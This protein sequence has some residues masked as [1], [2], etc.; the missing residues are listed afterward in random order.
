MSH[1][2]ERQVISAQADDVSRELTV[3]RD[4]G[5]QHT[6]QSISQSYPTSVDDLWGGVHDPRSARALVRTGQR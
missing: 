5:S 4:G 2:S 3:E 1:L 6:V